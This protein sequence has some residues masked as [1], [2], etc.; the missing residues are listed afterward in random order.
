[1]ALTK[2]DGTRTTN[3]KENIEI[4]RTHCEKLFNNKKLVSADALDL[5]SERPIETELDNNISWKEFTKA[6]SGL[7]TTNHRE[8]TKYQPKLSKP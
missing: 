5:I 7:K 3:N 8:P 6:I 4:M 1:M 2:N